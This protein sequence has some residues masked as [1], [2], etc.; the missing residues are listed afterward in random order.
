MIFGAYVLSESAAIP[1]SRFRYF[2]SPLGQ[3]VAGV[4]L[5]LGLVGGSGLVGWA[6]ATGTTWAPRV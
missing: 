5:G 2:K 1:K 6:I 3:R 4:F